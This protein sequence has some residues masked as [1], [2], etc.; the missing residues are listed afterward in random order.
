VA[1]RSHPAPTF[2][3]DRRQQENATDYGAVFEHVVI[4]QIVADRRALEDQILSPPAESAKRQSNQQQVGRAWA[5]TYK[6]EDEGADLRA[7][8]LVRRAWVET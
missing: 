2:W 4:F 5:G 1:A 8:R 7:G 6:L 3:R